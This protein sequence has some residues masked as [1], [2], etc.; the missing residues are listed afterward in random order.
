MSWTFKDPREPSNK[1][2]TVLVYMRSGRSLRDLKEASK[3]W[4]ALP[5]WKC[6]ICGGVGH[7]ESECTTKKALDKYAKTCDKE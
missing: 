4:K 2:D 1:T 5:K 3:V 7:I 6:I